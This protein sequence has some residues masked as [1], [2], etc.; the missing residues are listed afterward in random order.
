LTHVKTSLDPPFAEFD[1]DGE[2]AS[3][4][5]VAHRDFLLD[6]SQGVIVA[7]VQVSQEAAGVVLRGGIGL[8]GGDPSLSQSPPIEQWRSDYVL[9]TPDKYSFDFLVFTAPVQAHV[10]LDGLAVDGKLCETGDLP[11]YTVY[12][13]Q[14][15]FPAID[16]N[17][18]SPTNVSPGRQNDGVHRVQ[19]D[20]PIGVVVYG[21]DLRVSYAYAGGTELKDLNPR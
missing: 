15:S 3:T 10:F 17:Q 8:P 19:A 21:F 20:Y 16:P 13:C 2:G 6:A 1:L 7:D 9:L 18:P 5:L 11:G 4:T 14:L 12:R